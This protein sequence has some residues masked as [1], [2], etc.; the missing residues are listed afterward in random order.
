MGEEVEIGVQWGRA[1][2]KLPASIVGVRRAEATATG[3]RWLHSL[4][5]SEPIAAKDE[6]VLR[7]WLEDLARND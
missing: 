2:L 5:F 7:T 4:K 3:P 1:E 6:R